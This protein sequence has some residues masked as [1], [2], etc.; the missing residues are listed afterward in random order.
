MSLEKYVRVDLKLLLTFTVIETDSAAM[1]IDD[2]NADATSSCLKTI[3][4]MVHQSKVMELH[5]VEWKFKPPPVTPFRV[6]YC[7]RF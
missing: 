7:V 2:P 1:E 3:Q 5:L 6:P 4:A